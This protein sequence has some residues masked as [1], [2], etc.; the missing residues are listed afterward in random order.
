MS[1]YACS[2]LH[3]NLDLYKQIKSFLKREDTVYFLGDAG[4]RGKYNWETIKAV[5]DDRQFFYIRGN[6][7]DMLEECMN[8]YLSNGLNGLRN[9]DKY[10]Q[11]SYN[12]GRDTF[13]DW[14]QEEP[15]KQR[16]YYHKLMALPNYLKYQNKDGKLI[17]LSHAGFH[18]NPEHPDWYGWCEDLIWDREHIW[19]RW[20]H[21]ADENLII[22]HG[23]TPIQ[24]LIDNLQWLDRTIKMPELP[25]AYWYCDNHKCCIDNGT[26]FTHC[27]TLLDL[28][29][30]ETHAFYDEKYNP[31]G[32]E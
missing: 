12:G 19:L 20:P 23:H 8:D 25:T 2:D 22:I 13:R 15:M 16:E 11:L 5:L 9:S 21:D 27:I 6:H 18:P 1:V 10:L 14:L 31:E 28:D 17:V 4:D 24:V 32:E 29:T 26:Y 3:G 7:D 30:F